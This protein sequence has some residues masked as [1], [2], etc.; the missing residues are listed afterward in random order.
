MLQDITVKQDSSAPAQNAGGSNSSLLTLVAAIPS[1]QDVVAQSLTPKVEA[2]DLSG[3]YPGTVMH[4]LGVAGAFRQGVAPDFGG[5][6][7]RFR[8]AIQAIEEVSKACLSTGFIAWCQVACTWYLQNTHNQTLKTQLLPKVANGEVMAGTGL[9]NPMKFFAGIEKI[10]LIATPVEGGYL[11][12]GRLPWVS[13]L[14]PGHYFG[15]VAKRSTDDSHLM[16]IVSDEMDGVSLRK[17]GQFIALEGTGTFACV[18]RDAFI[19]EDYLL[20]DPCED[21]IQQIRPGF[22]LTQVGMGLGLVSGCIQLMQRYQR[23]LGHV[24][25]FLE[26]QPSDLEAELT[27]ARQEAYRLGD[28]LDQLE[29]PISTSLMKDIVQARLTAGE[30]SVKAANAAMLH[31]G[32]RAY[33]HG[34]PEERRL[35]EA[36]FVAIVTPA[37]KQLKKMLYALTEEA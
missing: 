3:E 5:E 20:A 10:A 12:N 2:I 26:D 28:E 24:N 25:C 17:C 9:S 18:F 14:G 31:A 35:R 11:L 7:I 16:A 33:L 32:A 34:S 36:Y 13:N 6:G 4:Q 22:I 29:G 37:T 23:R 8:G 19:P 27:Q 1:I 21:Y 30:M 15:V